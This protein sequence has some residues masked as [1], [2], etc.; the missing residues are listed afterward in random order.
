MNCPSSRVKL[1]FLSCIALKQRL[2]IEDEEV[3]IV[4]FYI[5]RDARQIEVYFTYQVILQVFKQ[6]VFIFV[7]LILK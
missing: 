7:N 6:L 1:A 2:M 5:N 3:I 4:S